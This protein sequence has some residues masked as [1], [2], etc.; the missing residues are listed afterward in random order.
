MMTS[1]RL[2]DVSHPLPPP[3]PVR[4][5]L[6]LAVVS[7]SFFVLV[8][9]CSHFFGRLSSVSAIDLTDALEDQTW[10]D[11][12]RNG[13]KST[14]PNRWM[15]EDNVGGLGVCEMLLLTRC[16]DGDGDGIQLDSI[17]LAPLQSH[18][19]KENNIKQVGMGDHIAVSPSPSYLVLLLPVSFSCVVVV[20][21]FI[22][23][24]I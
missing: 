15:V 1:R 19:P 4:A 22:G 7:S 14:S 18:R 10:I 23:D 17:Q 9:D 6:P 3:F 2:V 8:F 11:Q 13:A 24:L 5:V 21:S 20:C 12:Q 16:V